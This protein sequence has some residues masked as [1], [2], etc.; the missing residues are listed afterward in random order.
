[1][2]KCTVKVAKCPNYEKIKKIKWLNEKLKWQLY[3]L[4]VKMF[5]VAKVV[6]L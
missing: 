3:S 4:N 5:K 6:L 2:P 1:M